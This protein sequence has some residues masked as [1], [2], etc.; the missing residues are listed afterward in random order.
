MGICILSHA[1]TAT[2]HVVEFALFKTLHR[3]VYFLR[4]FKQF[5]FRLLTVLNLTLQIEPGQDAKLAQSNCNRRH[6]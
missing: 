2:I 5:C 1:H 3:G 6:I 4:H